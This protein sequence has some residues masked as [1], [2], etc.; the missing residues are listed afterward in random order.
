MSERERGDREREREGGAGGRHSEFSSLAWPRPLFIRH[1][2]DDY[3]YR[4]VT[5][6]SPR[7]RN[8]G[9]ETETRD[10]SV[11]ARLFYVCVW[12]PRQTLGEQRVYICICVCVVLNDVRAINDCTERNTNTSTH[13]QSHQRLP[14][15]KLG[16]KLSPQAR[17][18]RAAIAPVSN[19]S[20]RVSWSL[21]RH[22]TTPPSPRNESGNLSLP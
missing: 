14:K 18:Y 9:A 2:Y 10:V 22:P 20:R 19:A 17:R 1:Y 16:V 13:T 15:T 12:V 6:C 3:F 21:L 4:R 8:A 5:Q 7:P 11:R